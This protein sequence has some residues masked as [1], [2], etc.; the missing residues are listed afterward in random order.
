MI[1]LSIGTVAAL[2]VAAAVLLI[3]LE[4]LIRK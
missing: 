1:A 4:I 3:A 2:A